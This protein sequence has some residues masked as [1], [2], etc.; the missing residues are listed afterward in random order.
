MKLCEEQELRTVENKVL[1]RMF[2]SVQI[3]SNRMMEK[4][5]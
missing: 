1:R 4:I 5:T 2:A 3:G